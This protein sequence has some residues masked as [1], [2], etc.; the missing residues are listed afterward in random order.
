MNHRFNASVIV[1]VICVLESEAATPGETR[2]ETMFN[3]WAARNEAK[4]AEF[5]AFLA[6]EGLDSVYPL[7]QLART[8]SDWRTCG[9][10]PFELP[11]RPQWPAARSTLRLAKLLKDESVLHGGEVVSAYRNSALNRCARG[12]KRSSHTTAYALDI[13]GIEASAESLCQFHRRRGAKFDMG[14]SRY[15]SGRIHLD[16]NGYRTWGNDY[17]SKTS[18]CRKYW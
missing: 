9:G 15:V 3:S 8:A 16:A 14:L 6:G 2:S 5:K 13:Q 1:L 11:P 17:T 4:V 18:F 12:S 10:S 7:H